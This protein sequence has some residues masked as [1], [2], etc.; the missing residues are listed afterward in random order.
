LVST[1][2]CAEEEL[3]RPEFVH[4]NMELVENQNVVR[5]QNWTDLVEN[6]ECRTKQIRIDMDDLPASRGIGFQEPR[7]R[8]LE[9][10]LDE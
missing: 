2:K 10:P 5:L 4:P 3:K 9:K 1:W 8:S 7:Q 6:E